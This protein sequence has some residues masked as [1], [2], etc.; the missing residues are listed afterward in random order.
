MRRNLC[1]IIILIFI[2]CSPVRKY[3]SLP[4]VKGWESSILEFE[5]L[6]TIRTYTSDAI[7]F[8]GSS[9]IALWS[10]IEKD[11]APYPVIQRGF[12]GSRLIDFIVYA[13]RIV[14]P[15]NCRAIVMFIANDIIGNEQDRSP[16]DV[17]SLFL[18]SLKIIRKS[19]P[20]TPV[21]WISVTP[22]PSRLKAWS[23]IK[24]ANI[25][26]RDICSGEKNTYFIPTDFAFLNSDG[27]PVKEYFRPD[28]LHLNDQGYKIWTSI[29]KK[30]L[31]KIVPHSDLTD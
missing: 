12:G 13:D 18:N 19:H 30:E 23:E 4:G 16:E 27:L 14:S 9:S 6:D 2:S 7:L 1:F 15:H 17:A 5:K 10:T 25:L 26:I 20:K 3:Q 28:M 11:M 24:K 21:F 29:I 22:T 8:T 31:N